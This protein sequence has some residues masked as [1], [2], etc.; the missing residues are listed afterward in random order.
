MT[1]TTSSTPDPMQN[2]QQ[3]AMPFA[4]PPF[5]GNPFMSPFMP[6]G[7]PEG[8]A[9]AM[10]PNFG[11]QPPMAGN[12]GQMGFFVT[13]AQYQ[14][15]MQQYFQQMMASAAFNMP[16]PMQQQF[17]RPES[18]A[19]SIKADES[20]GAA[21]GQ[22]DI[23]DRNLSPKPTKD[24]LITCNGES[25]SETRASTSNKENTP[26]DDTESVASS[27][28]AENS[29][30]EA[31]NG[32]RK[33]STE[34]GPQPGDKE[35]RTASL[36][37]KQM[38]EIEK[39]IT[40]RTQNKNIKQMD[41]AELAELM[42][43][44]PAAV[45]Q[46]PKRIPPYTYTAAL[47]FSSGQPEQTEQPGKQTLNQLRSSF[48]LPP[49][50]AG[51]PPNSVQQQLQNTVEPDFFHQPPMAAPIPQ[52]SQNGHH[53]AVVE[54][55]SIASIA[56]ARLSMGQPGGLIEPPPQAAN[57]VKKRTSHSSENG[58]PEGDEPVWVM[59]DSYLRRL[60]RDQEQTTTTT[61]STVSGE[62]PNEHHQQSP[63]NEQ[64]PERDEQETDRL[65]VEKDVS[66][67]KDRRAS[68]KSSKETLVHEP[69]VL[70]EGVLFRARYL[71]STQLVCEGRSTKTARMAQ[72]QE[73]VARV[74]VR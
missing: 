18:Q 11:Q 45:A 51:L 25:T 58:G 33:S 53:P 13:P 24:E 4:M 73:A 9:P 1:N 16:F 8:Q 56:Q 29:S 37:Q 74:K 64:G 12:N 19:S 47:P 70:I 36:I 46:V 7:A 43:H 14:E 38:S 61:P 39:E 15:M 31:T 21:I 65:L 32:P 41:D 40:R 22:I 3:Q 59:R 30:S 26:N 23:S 62:W 35:S 60:Q 34:T 27:K 63:T 28:S 49:E 67:A 6:Q 55:P 71:G 50:G 2:M 57:P 5:Y 69:A 20:L 44:L 66:P 42:G 48:N 17:A 10:P 54:T 52:Q 68:H 72:A